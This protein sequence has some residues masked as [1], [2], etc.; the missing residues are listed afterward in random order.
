MKFIALLTCHLYVQLSFAQTG[1]T[2]DTT[3][4]VEVNS[5]FSYKMMEPTQNLRKVSILMDERADGNLKNSSLVI[6]TSLIAIGDYQYSNTDSKFGYLMRHPT[7]KNQIGHVVTEAVIHSFQVSLTGSVNNWL[8]SYAEILYNPE[9]SFGTGLITDIERNQ[10]QLR[11]GFVAFGDLNKF[12]IYGAIGK[13]DSPFGQ[14]GSVSPFTNSTLWH[15][16]GGICYGAQLSFKKWNIHGTVMA[17]QG[18]AQFRGMNTTV[19]DSTNIPSLINN[20]VA[21]LNYTLFFNETISLKFGG[22]YL[23]GSTY[24]QEFPVQHFDPAKTN[25][26]ALTAY[27]YLN[28]N[29]RIILKGGYAKTLNVWPGTHNPT[30]PLDQYEA[31]RV[32]SFDLGASYNLNA[33]KPII[34]RISAEFSDFIAGPHGSPWERQNQI[35][36]GFSAVI[37]QSSKLFIEGFR[38]DGYVPLNWI[39]GSDGT[40]PFPPGVTHSS[41]DA[42]SY[43]IVLGCQIT[44]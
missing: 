3:F 15:A 41:H 19:A 31:F 23:R 36:A 32:S 35:V 20:F 44:F 9:Q 13:M 24:N 34:Y 43:G 16:F 22:S 25:N 12:P 8:A 14:T 38:T 18:G 42:F 6:G 33:G 26:P 7:S 21:D 37:K 28:I 1:G 30:P 10:L 17:A 40:G 4:K 11:K 39:S 29:D 27:G 5:A 2:A